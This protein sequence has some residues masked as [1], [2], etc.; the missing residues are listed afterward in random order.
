MGCVRA[1]SQC[2]D[3][4]HEPHGEPY[5]LDRFQYLGLAFSVFRA[6]RAEAPTRTANKSTWPLSG[7]ST[8]A[9]ASIAWK[10][11]AKHVP[12]LQ[13]YDWWASLAAGARTSRLMYGP[14]KRLGQDFLCTLLSWSLLA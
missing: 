1:A 9:N 6:G 2:H 10:R 7:A 8:R 14:A 11:Q 12:L 4:M 3:P 13:S 5:E